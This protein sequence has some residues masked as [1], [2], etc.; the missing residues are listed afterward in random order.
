MKKIKNFDQYLDINNKSNSELK[1]LPL[2]SIDRA[3]NANK[4]AYEEIPLRLT[5]LKEE[6]LMS[7]GINH[8]EN[9]N[10]HIYSLMQLLHD[11]RKIIISDN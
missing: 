11:Y 8:F 1:P 5:F 7:C 10:L 3:L 4:L 6:L 9:D 2:N